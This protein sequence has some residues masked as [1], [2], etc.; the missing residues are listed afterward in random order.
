MLLATIVSVL[1][2]TDDN[3]CIGMVRPWR[4]GDPC[5]LVNLTDD[6]KWPEDAK[7]HGFEYFLEIFTAKEILETC[8]SPLFSFEEQV[9]IVLYYAEYDA[10]PEWVESRF[11][12]YRGASRD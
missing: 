7:R 2:H 6:Y 11:S 5:C 3:L 1:E 9:E 12:S 8:T 4:S 10:S